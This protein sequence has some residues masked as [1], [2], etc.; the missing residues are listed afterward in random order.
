ME[1]YIPHSKVEDKFVD[2]SESVTQKET[3]NVLEK[4]AENERQLPKDENQEFF[5][6][7]YPD[8]P[9]VPKN[10]PSKYFTNTVT[11]KDCQAGSSGSKIVP[12]DYLNPKIMQFGYRNAKLNDS[13]CGEYRFKN[14]VDSEKLKE[15]EV[16]KKDLTESTNK[17]IYK[18]KYGNRETVNEDVVKTM[19]VDN[20]LVM[21]NA[22]LEEYPEPIVTRGVFGFDNGSWS[23]FQRWSKDEP[24]MLR[25]SAVSYPPV[26]GGGNLG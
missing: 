3:V 17:I 18:F 11:F 23:G 16:A 7:P 4:S 26:D 24:M 22:Q 15:V 19:G 9:A 2:P 1:T 20:L 5:I 21:G 10:G 8:G 14:S 6:K 12:Q 25:N 13:L